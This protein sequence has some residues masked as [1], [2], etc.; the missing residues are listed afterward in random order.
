MDPISNIAA[1][2]QIMTWCRPG[3]KALSEPMI[4]SF[5]DAYTLGLDELTLSQI[6]IN[7]IIWGNL[8]RCG[9]ITRSY[10]KVNIG[11]G[12]GLC[13]PT[14]S[15]KF[16]L[17]RIVYC[18]LMIIFQ[19]LFYFWHFHSWESVSKISSVMCL[20]FRPAALH[21][22]MANIRHVI[23]MCQLYDLPSVNI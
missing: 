10:I 6:D 7:Q 23:Q 1:L 15:Q 5:T 11:W 4:A 3:D 17:K 12:H 16:N 21:Q 13:L 20:P 18:F 22:L 8:A 2:G 19:F 14:T 9:L